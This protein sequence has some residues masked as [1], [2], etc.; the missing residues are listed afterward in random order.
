ML[1]RRLLGY[2][3]KQVRQL[4][5]DRDGLLAVA[6]D[7]VR[8]LER[9]VVDLKGDLLPA[10]AELVRKDQQIDSLREELDEARHQVEK[11]GEQLDQLRQEADRARQAQENDPAHVTLELVLSEVGPI[12]TAAQEAATRIIEDA[13]VTIQERLEQAEGAR[14]MLAGQVQELSEWRDR[15][16]PMIGGI[17]LR[18]QETRAT[19][20]EVPER[21]ADALSPLV[22]LL[23]SMSRQ[24]SE[25]AR[26]SVPPRFED[27]KDAGQPSGPASENGAESS[28]VIR[29]DANG[30]LQRVR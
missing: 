12:L 28:H 7:R 8:T 27:G 26:V 21:I 24:L 14:Q 15:I 10:R 2:S 5:F 19:V 20:T 13:Q 3:S 25:F 16:G 6:E 17:Q 18:M 23:T 4:L 9:E 30:D 1:R 29:V 11:L 22:D